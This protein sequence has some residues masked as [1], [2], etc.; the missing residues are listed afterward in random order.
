MQNMENLKSF[1]FCAVICNFKLFINVRV[2]TLTFSNI[3]INS[4]N[5]KRLAHMKNNT[6][7]MLVFVVPFG[8]Y[9]GL[10]FTNLLLEKHAR[11]KHALKKGHSV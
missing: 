8:L 4:S 6:L 11:H 9:S 2:K 3:L 1:W 5:K 10:R 7:A